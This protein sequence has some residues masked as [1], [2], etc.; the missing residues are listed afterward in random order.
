M[1][2]QVLKGGRPTDDEIAAI[3]SAR[4]AKKA[5]QETSEETCEVLVSQHELKYTFRDHTVTV[6][7]DWSGDGSPL[8]GMQWLGGMGLARFFDDRARFPEGSLVGKRVVEVGAGCGMT[9][10]LLALLGAD[11]TL[12]DMDITKAMPNVEANLVGDEAA[13]GRLKVATMDWFAPELERFPL[14][15]DI[16]VAGDCCYQVRHLCAPRAVV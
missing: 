9:S 3:R 7:E 4:A 11:V 6:Q 13:R 10:I 8:A 15:F 1:A 5:E 16:I 14:P 2:S 12:T